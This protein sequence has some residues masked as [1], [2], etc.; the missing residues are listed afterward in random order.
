MNIPKSVVGAAFMIAASLA[1]A[2]G[3]SDRTYGDVIRK[4]EKA[5]NEYAI[6]QGK[7]SP[8]LTHYRYGM[9]LDIAKVIRTTPTDS[10][11]NNVMPAQ[12]TYEDS[13]GNLNILEYRTAGTN[14]RR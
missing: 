1:M 11:C 3:S 7:P 6:A 14:C 9:E 13:S 5:I 12:M 2:D 8:K 4:N 10:T